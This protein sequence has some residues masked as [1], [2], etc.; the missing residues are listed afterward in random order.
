MALTYDGEYLEGA[1]RSCAYSFLRKSTRESHTVSS[2]K[3]VLRKRFDALLTLYQPCVLGV[4]QPDKDSVLSY[5]TCK[6]SSQCIFFAW[7]D[8][9]TSSSTM[10]A[11]MGGMRKTSGNY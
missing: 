4:L 9:K 5:F 7:A 1:N 6:E 2:V 10:M 8:L 11:L 3:D